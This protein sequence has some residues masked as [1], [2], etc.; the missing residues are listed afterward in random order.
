MLSFN[1]KH[2]GHLVGTATNL[3]SRKIR[4]ACNQ[5]VAKLNLLI[6]QFGKCNSETLYSLFKLHCL[7][8][9]GYQLFNYESKSASA[10]PTTWRK[11]VRRIFRLPYNTHCRNYL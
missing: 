1:K 3:E 6:L 2:V 11:C 5:M 8:L 4:E 10:M 7:S 9:Y